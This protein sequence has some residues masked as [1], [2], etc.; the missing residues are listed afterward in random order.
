MR[1][2]PNYCIDT[3]SGAARCVK[4]IAPSLS[5]DML[6]PDFPWIHAMIVIVMSLV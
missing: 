3:L 5:S 6:S 4:T 2:E 1:E